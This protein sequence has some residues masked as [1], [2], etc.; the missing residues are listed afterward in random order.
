MQT[1]GIKAKIKKNDRSRIKKDEMIR[2][3]QQEEISEDESPY[4][5][6]AKSKN[7]SFLNASEAYQ[8]EVSLGKNEE[9]Y[10][11][12]AIGLN[13]INGSNVDRLNSR[14]GGSRAFNNTRDNWKEQSANASEY[15]IQQTQVQSN[16][17]PSGAHSLPRNYKNPVGFE[18]DS[19]SKATSSAVSLTLSKQNINSVNNNNSISPKPNKW[20]TNKDNSG[21][22]NSY[23]GNGTAATT[24]KFNDMQKEVNLMY[25]G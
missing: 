22:T 24:Q 23:V 12:E 4:H 16:V 14:I 17:N 8:Q 6:D 21:I 18:N 9:N 20:S 13:L 7:K 2:E 1:Q 11:Q 3:E 25:L 5:K 15:Q 19:T 10:Y